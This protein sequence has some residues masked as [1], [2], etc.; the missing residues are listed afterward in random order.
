[1]LFGDF[2]GTPH[3]TISSILTSGLAVYLAVIKSGNFCFL[4]LVAESGVLCRKCGTADC[5]EYHG[6]WFRKE[7][8]DLCTGEIFNELPILRVRFCDGATKSLFPAEL[9]RG[10]ATVTSTLETAFIAI[11]DGL[12]EAMQWA[13]AGGDGDELVSERTVRRWK[14]RTMDRVPIASA[15]L[16]FPSVPGQPSAA[17]LE[18]FLTHLH[19]HHLLAL[20]RQWGFSI[21]DIPG[22]Q[23]PPH[24]TSCPKPVFQ[25]QRPAHNPPSEYLPRGTKSCLYRRG[26][27]PDE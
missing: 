6:Q 17:K 26:R 7:I 22:L 2:S 21:L 18:N 11:K 15:A 8:I 20:R 10:R 5:A 16:N 3:S 4:S 14:K 12:D 1:M 9:W 23:K 19:P 13:M 27:P 25:N 24:S